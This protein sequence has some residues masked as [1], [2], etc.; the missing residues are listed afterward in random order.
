VATK[1]KTPIH[2][3]A[4]FAETFYG[5]KRSALGKRALALSTRQKNLSLVVLV[6]FDYA[7]SKLS[8]LIEHWRNRNNQQPEQVHFLNT[9]KLKIYYV[10]ILGTDV[11]VLVGVASF[12]AEHLHGQSF[13]VH[14]GEN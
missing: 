2:S 6:L 9:E 10:T 5:L 14:D 3:G 11:K 4:S 13:D 7:K 8:A 1:L 12:V